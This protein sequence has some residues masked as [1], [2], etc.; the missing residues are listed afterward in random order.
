MS[1]EDKVKTSKP[2][3]VLTADFEA[4]LDNCLYEAMLAGAECPVEILAIA[5]RRAK[6]K[7]GKGGSNADMEQAYKIL[8]IADKA[9]QEKRSK[10][11]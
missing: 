5:E 10:R 7:Q 3:P 9:R 6:T 11:Q 4:A 8:D 2:K 1:G